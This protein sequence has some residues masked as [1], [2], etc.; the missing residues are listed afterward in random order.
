MQSVESF[1]ASPD[2]LWMETSPPAPA[3]ASSRYSS[4]QSSSDDISR[5]GSTRSSQ[6]RPISGPAST[7]DEVQTVKAKFRDHSSEE[8]EAEDD[9]FDLSAE[10]SIAYLIQKKYMKDD[11]DV[12][13]PRLG[14]EI[15]YNEPSPYRRSPPPPMHS[16][17][18]HPFTKAR[19]QESGPRKMS[20]VHLLRSNSQ[21]EESDG[22]GT[23]ED[24]ADRAEYRKVNRV[25]RKLK[26]QLDPL[27]YTDFW[28]TTE[29]VGDALDFSNSVRN[30]I[31]QTATFDHETNRLY[32]WL[33][34]MIMEAKE[35]PHRLE[36]EL[37]KYAHLDKMIE[38]IVEFK[39]RPP[40]LPFKELQMVETASDLLRY[41]R[42]RFGNRY[43]LLDRHRQRIV[44]DTLL[45]GLVF[46]TPTPL[47]PTGWVPQNVNCMSERE[48]ESVFEEGQW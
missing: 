16:F 11:P 47:T 35:G 26:K 10:A 29:Q 12:S 18:K 30:C 6:R 25:I 28:F 13:P 22:Y 45:D 44:M 41:W 32:R 4:P 7:D 33:N 36:F 40:S 19:C 20:T 15:K 23:E 39:S 1:P 5:S 46:N 14:K 37:I 38:T 17:E 24:I 48:A 21:S 34:I 27:N 2:E 9:E 43:Y 31:A 8:D 3:D 42:H